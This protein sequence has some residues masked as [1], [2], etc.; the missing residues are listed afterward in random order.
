MT[1]I[2]K[3]KHTS[4]HYSMTSL[5]YNKLE[6]TYTNFSKFASIFTLQGIYSFQYKFI[7]LHFFGAIYGKFIC[8]HLSNSIH[9]KHFHGEMKRICD[10]ITKVIISSSLQQLSQSSLSLKLYYK[11]LTEID[12]YCLSY[13]VLLYQSYDTSLR[14]LQ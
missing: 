12:L 4:S 2:L 7:I 13:F 3:D 11:L 14:T 6:I 10:F 8:Q 1:K 9:T 5:S